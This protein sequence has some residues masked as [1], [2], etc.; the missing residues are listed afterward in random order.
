LSDSVSFIVPVRDLQYGLRDRVQMI[1]EILGELTD[2]F[3]LLIVDYGSRDETRDVAMD[4]VREYPQVDFVDRGD[5]ADLLAA[6]ESGIHRTRGATIFVHDPTQPLGESALRSLWRMRHDEDLVMAQSRTD[7]V[8]RQP[9]LQRPSG[10]RGST[11]RSSLQMIR[12]CAI[13]PDASRE[14]SPNVERLTRTDL[15]GQPID[16]IRLPKLLTRLRRLTTWPEM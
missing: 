16:S 15:A 12:R 7:E 5:D 3:E 6:V 2:D 4:L 9:Y 1:L 14:Q 13:G 8:V 10:R 11:G